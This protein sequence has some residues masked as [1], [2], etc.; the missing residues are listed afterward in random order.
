MPKGFVLTTSA[1][2]HEEPCGWVSAEGIREENAEWVPT[3]THTHRMQTDNP[4][5]HNEGL[6]MKRTG[7]SGV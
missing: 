1:V 3:H 7:S 2:L 4:A 6:G 5:A